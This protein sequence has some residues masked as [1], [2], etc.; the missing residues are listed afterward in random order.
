MTIDQA[1]SNNGVQRSAQSQFV[2]IPE[3]ACAPADAER[4]TAPEVGMIRKLTPRLLVT[5]IGLTGAAGQAVLLF[6]NLVDCYPYKMMFNP[7][8][9]FYEGIAY[10][11]LVLAPL[12]AIFAGAIFLRRVPYLIAAGACVSC[13]SIFLLI[14]AVA[15]PILGVDMGNTANFDHTTPAAVFRDFT[16]LA[17]KLL[18]AGGAIGAVCGLIAAVAFRVTKR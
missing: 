3:R 18:V 6:H 8:Y 4:W 14:F 16:E 1:A 17:L 12:I 2:I 5:V 15:H 10:V 11:G 7:S 9:R 13:P